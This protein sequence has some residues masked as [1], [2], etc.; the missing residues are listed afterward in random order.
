MLHHNGMIQK[1]KPVKFKHQV[2]IF[3]K[4]SLEKVFM[5][6]CHKGMIRRIRELNLLNFNIRQRLAQNF[7]RKSLYDAEP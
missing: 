2:E 6:P 7:S 5:I 3:S 4:L 1:N